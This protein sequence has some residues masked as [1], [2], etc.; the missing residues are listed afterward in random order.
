M[1]DNLHLVIMAGGIGSRFWPLSTPDLPK[2]FIDILGSG[3]T[4]IQSTYDRFRGLVDS[5]NI[6]IVTNEKY[7]EIVQRQLPEVAREH[8]LAEPAARNTAPC[9]AWACWKINSI[10]PNAQVVITPSDAYVKD[11]EVFQYIIKQCVDFASVSDKLVTIG[12]KPTRPEI[13]YGYICYDNKS[14]FDNL[15]KV[16]SFKEKPN[17]DLAQSYFESG[18]YLWNAGLF[19]WNV[20]T[21][22]A[23]IRRYKPLIAQVMD[24]LIIPSADL[25][26]FSTC[27][28]I[29]IDYALMEPAASDGYVFTC[30]ADFGWSDLGNWQSLYEKL[31]PDEM[32][33]VIVGNVTL[34]DCQNCIVHMHKVNKVVLQGMN[35]FIVTEKN[36][37]ILICK[38]EKEQDIKL[39]H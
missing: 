7:V 14:R 15:Y 36:G 3:R 17:I 21:L 39:Y 30:P 25:H 19:I 6:W 29:S 9:I 33:N 24:Q 13:G 11:I 34:H 26:V 20:K 12:I 38:R 35:D 1:I 32:G 4:L 37:N 8:I 18:L 28:K 16:K 10:H 27:E 5:V 23:S 22:I 31:D 2:Q